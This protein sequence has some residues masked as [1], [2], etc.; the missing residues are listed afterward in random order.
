M[1]NASPH[2]R[3]SPRRLDPLALVI[4]LTAADSGLS[5]RG[6]LALQRLRQRQLETIE[7][8]RGAFVKI[9]PRT[10]PP[11]LDLGAI[12][13]DSP[14]TADYH[15]LIVLELVTDFPERG[16]ELRALLKARRHGLDARELAE[17]LWHND[18]DEA[19][20]AAAAKYK[21]DPHLL[22]GTLWVALKPLYESVAAAIIRHFDVLPGSDDCPV[23]GGPPWA[24][25]GGQLICGVCET[26]WQG[27]L[28][29]RSFRTSDGPQ[30]VGA[31]RLYDAVSGQRLVDLDSALLA[32]AFDAG[33]LIELLQLLD[34]PI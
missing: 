8:S 23:C 4:S 32:Q 11:L 21:L 27:D 3:L 17:A 12:G 20:K 18:G 22:A 1:A 14:L 7:R 25:S 28:S 6:M 34:K 19:F 30:A 5:R 33:P 15:S 16:A 24:R 9:Q 29:K 26:H 13:R 31:T 2:A 10:E